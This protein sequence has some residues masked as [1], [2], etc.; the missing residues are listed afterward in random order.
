[1]KSAFTDELIVRTLPNDESKKSRKYVKN[2]PPYFSI[3]AMKVIK[4][5]NVKHLLVDIPS[6][7]RAFDEGRLTAH[8]I[9]WDVKQGSH[10]V[11]KENHS[12]NTIT[13]MIY[14]PDSVLDG[15]YLLNLQIA[16]FVSDASPSRPVIYKI[17]KNKNFK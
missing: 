3:E 2:P 4:D 15:N 10:V 14:V 11:D 16:P 13:E 5:L 8:H 17:I 1:L 6:V 12:L 9:F 7:D